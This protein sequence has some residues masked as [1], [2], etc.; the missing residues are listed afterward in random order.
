MSVVRFSQKLEFDHVVFFGLIQACSKCSE[1]NQQYR[2]WKENW[3]INVTLIVA[4]GNLLVR[5]H[6]CEKCWVVIDNALDQS[7]CISF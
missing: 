6:D 2:F 5:P 1:I 3:S 7:D 4:F